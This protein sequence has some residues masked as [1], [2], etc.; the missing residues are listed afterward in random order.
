MPCSPFASSLE[1]L[2]ISNWNIQDFQVELTRPKQQDEIAERIEISKVRSICHN[3]FVAFFGENFCTAE[4]VFHGLTQEPVEK[5]REYLI[6][7]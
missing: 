5:N 1:A 6:G 3:A 4:R 7:T 2:F